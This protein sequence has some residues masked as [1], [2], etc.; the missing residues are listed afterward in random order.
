MDLADRQVIGWALSKGLTANLTVIP[1][2]NAA[3]QRRPITGDLI[4]HSDRGIQ[5]ACKEFTE[6]LK[7][8]KLVT[9][10]MS[11]KG[12]C[13]DNAPAESFFKTL[14]AELRLDG[15]FT[16]YPQ[17]RQSIFTFIELWYNRKRL[18]SALAYRTPAQTEQLLTQHQAA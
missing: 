7:A 13:W 11:R 3:C 18:H 9:Q 14:K 16:S 1:A 6:T 10:S 15:K 8:N 12:N 17:A 4:F 5:Y 2:W